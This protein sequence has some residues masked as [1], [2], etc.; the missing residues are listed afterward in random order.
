MYRAIAFRVEKWTILFHNYRRGKQIAI[1][2]KAISLCTNG[3]QI[4]EQAP[5]AVENWDTVPE[6][7]CC[8]GANW[9]TDRRY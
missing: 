2:F 8:R 3:Q 1:Y 5:A 4:N 7:S 9:F 6:I